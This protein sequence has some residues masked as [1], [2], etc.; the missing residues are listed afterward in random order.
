MI[1]IER[2]AQDPPALKVRRAPS[3]AKASEGKRETDDSNRE[4]WTRTIRD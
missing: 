3:Y 1:V 4:T 2:R